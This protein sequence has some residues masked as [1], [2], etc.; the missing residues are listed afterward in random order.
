MPTQFEPCMLSTLDNP[1]NP[2]DQ[3]DE[4]FEYDTSCGYNTSAFL[5]R[6]VQ[7]SY[8]VSDTDQ[9]LAIYQAIDEIIKENVNGMYVKVFQKTNS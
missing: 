9:D 4:W 8:E 7:S 6:I 5:A 1:Y 3:F 2:F